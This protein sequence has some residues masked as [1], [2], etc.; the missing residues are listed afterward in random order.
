MP[1]IISISRSSALRVS[2]FS[3]PPPTSRHSSVLYGK[4]SHI[5]YSQKVHF[6]GPANKWTL[7]SSRKSSGNDSSRI[8][9]WIRHSISSRHHLTRGIKFANRNW[10]FSEIVY[11]LLQIHKVRCVE[12]R[13]L[14]VGLGCSE[15]HCS[16]HSYICC[17]VYNW[18]YF[19][20]G[21]RWKIIVKYSKPQLRQTPSIS[22]DVLM[23]WA[24]FN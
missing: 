18:A 10:I 11:P 19:A 5:E 12:I 1:R 3:L 20:R 14:L 6:Q 16:S 23:R 15:N 7:W 2:I 8:L 13:V 4:E 22:R 9:G 24:L 17:I 21:K